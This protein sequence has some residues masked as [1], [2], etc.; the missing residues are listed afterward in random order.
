MSFFQKPSRDAATEGRLLA[1]PT[2]P[3]GTAPLG[4]QP[5]G[6]DGDRSNGGAQGDRDGCLYVPKGY[7]ANQ[8]AP[9]VLMMH[10][11]GGNASNGLP[12]FR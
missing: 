7:R 3:T 9:L 6:L 2:K 10:G 4:L 8:P 5:L 1:R 11:A 12:P